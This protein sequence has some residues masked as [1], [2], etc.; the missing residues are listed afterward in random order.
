MKWIPDSEDYAN[1]L[2]IGELSDDGF[3]SFSATSIE[4]YRL[5]LS[6]EKHSLHRIPLNTQGKIKND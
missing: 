6:N 2:M 1:V 4:L 3:S 5:I